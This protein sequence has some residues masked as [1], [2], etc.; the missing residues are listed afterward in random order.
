MKISY[1]WLKQYLSIDNTPEELDKILTDI[2]LEVEGVEKRQSIKG[3][4][5]GL[6]IGKVVEKEKHPN[7]DKLSV[8]K[9]DV[10]AEEFLPIVCGAPNIDANQKV[11]VATVGTTLYDG[12][13]SFQIKKSKIRG[14]VSMGMI[15]AEDE[16]GL[17]QGHDGIMVLEE[18]AEI[19]TKA[20][21]YFNIETDYIFEI[22][23]TPNR[24]DAMSH[25]GVARDLKAYFNVHGAS[26]KLDLPDLSGFP[27][28]QDE[29]PVSIE[30][31]NKEA[32]PRYAGLYIKNVKVQESPDWLKKN[33]ESI[34]ITPKNNIVDITNF[35]LHEF[36]QPL[37]A[38]D[39]DEIKGGKVLVRNL[40]KGSK[41][42]TLDGEERT[43]HQ[44]DLMICDADQGMCI[45]GVFGGEQSGVKESTKNLFLESA[46]FN[47]VAVRKASKRHALKTDASF[48][49]ERGVDPEAIIDAM[50]RAA[51]L[52]QEL[53]G[54][55]VASKI[56]DQYEEAIAPFTVNFDHQKNNHL[57]GENIPEDFVIK[58]FKELE[59]DIT[60]NT[61][62]KMNLSIPSYRVDVQRQ[63]DLSEEILRMYGYNAIPIPTEIKSALV[64]S[65]F[66]NPEKIRKI[67]F[68]HLASVGFNEIMNNSLSNPKLYAD[69]TAEEN[70]VKMLNP[71]S[72][73]LEVMRP[74]MLIDGLKTIA[75]NVNRQISEVKIFESGRIY[76]KREDKYIEDE[77]LAIW[78]SGKRH[79]ENWMNSNE[80][81]SFFYLKG[82][83]ENLLGRLGLS[84]LKYK[85]VENEFFSDAIEI[86][87]KKKSVAILGKV[88]AAEL[89]KADLDQE[90]Y[91]AEL[92]W[93]NIF[94]LVKQNNITYK[95][96]SKYPSVRRDL[97]LLVDK[98]TNFLELE[99]LA[100]QAE[101]QLL[102]EVGLFDV[103]EGDKLPEGKKS[104]AMYFLL[105]NEEK[106]MNDKVI[107][108]IMSKIQKAY[109]TKLNA[110]LR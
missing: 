87:A 4:L 105:Q 31:K 18:A 99:S 89:K 62:G 98:E 27:E 80:S 48:R 91:Y 85:A 53:A 68:D 24:A 70:M 3:G 73:E 56:E 33:L 88:T 96:V 39:A 6:V 50:K 19:G 108:K 57:L 25:I 83:V 59:I 95:A 8:T 32:C 14:E 36:G 69:K 38:F 93:E 16:I 29:L 17:G 86:K 101:N 54:G 63:A 74:E 1:N 41:F 107:D 34:G 78:V 46:Y 52:I 100:K 45:A 12:E 43:L 10:G 44:D 102:K 37:H 110:Q 5:E 15:C 90:T 65:E 97:S 42:K 35:V 13:G 40:E 81:V 84:A 26:L 67:A 71:L 106:T 11:V 2:G 64:T 58:L 47:P 21:D 23:L 30:I 103:Y 55:V 9:V 28:V 22:G 104:Y 20:A 109:E 61:D 51:L 49:F 66:I 92:N 60:A 77:K 82:I 94:N 75:Y 72:Q 79:K 7:A 76:S